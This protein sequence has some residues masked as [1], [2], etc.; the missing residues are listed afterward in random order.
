MLLLFVSVLFQT[1][2][3]LQFE[4]DTEPDQ[5]KELVQFDAEGSREERGNHGNQLFFFSYFK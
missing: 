4:S 3:G 2:H 1:R 5:L